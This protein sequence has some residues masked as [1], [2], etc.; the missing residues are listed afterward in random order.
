MLVH[1]VMT[2]NVVTVSP[3]TSVVD[4]LKIMK[5]HNFSRLPVVDRNGR[6]VGLV[7][8]NRLESVKPQTTASLM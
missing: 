3:N 2:R 8:Q 1:G 5:E 4:A 6:L 7:T